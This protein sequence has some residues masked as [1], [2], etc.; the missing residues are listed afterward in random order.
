MPQGTGQLRNCLVLSFSSREFDFAVKILLATHKANLTTRS[1]QILEV[2]K[3]LQQGVKIRIL[4]FIGS[5][6]L[7]NNILM[8]LRD[9][10][11]LRP[12]ILRDSFLRA[13]FLH[14]ANGKMWNMRVRDFREVQHVE[15]LEKSPQQALIQKTK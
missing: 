3:H 12:R 10:H 15:A 4:W 6:Q 8:E 14:Y 7:T 11:N 1:K 9:K 13:D 5:K 2:N